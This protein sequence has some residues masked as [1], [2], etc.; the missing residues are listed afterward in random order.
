MYSFSS[1]SL[2]FRITR[3]WQ[4]LIF[5]P[6]KGKITDWAPCRA[7]LQ[8]YLLQRV[9]P[10]QTA[11]DIVP[12]TIPSP[13]SHPTLSGLLDSLLEVE[14]IKIT[15]MYTK[16]FKVT[17]NSKIIIQH[18]QI[19]GIQLVWNCTAFKNIHSLLFQELGGKDGWQGG[20][21]Q[22][23]WHAVFAKTKILIIWLPFMWTEK[24]LEM[25]LFRFRFHAKFHARWNGRRLIWVLPEFSLKTRYQVP[26]TGLNS[27][28]CM[29]TGKHESHFLESEST[30]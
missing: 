27:P 20:Y 11:K 2:C 28:L 19:I 17:S 7:L 29:N 18:F 30:S 1:F 21:F 14:G 9:H 24:D 26:D 25:L 8:S 12:L 3:K 6:S 23:V 5:L 4:L 16:H 22:A 15:Q 13:L 10:R